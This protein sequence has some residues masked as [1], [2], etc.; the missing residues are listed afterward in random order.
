MAAAFGM[1]ERA[2]LGFVREQVAG[3]AVVGV[4]V[5]AFVDS[6][7]VEAFDQDFEVAGVVG[8]GDE[9]VADGRARQRLDALDGGFGRGSFKGGAA[10]D[11]RGHP[12]STG[13]APQGVGEEGDAVAVEADAADFS[14]YAVHEDGGALG[15]PEHG[16]EH[17]VEVGLAEVSVLAGDGMA[18]GG[19][20]AN[21]G[22]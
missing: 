11:G 19:G 10:E 16:D 21:G 14:R 1:G 6:G 4:G 22:E 9:K 2:S 17:A 20:V 13:A 12:G 18:G 15:W 3:G 8:V 5:D 7:D